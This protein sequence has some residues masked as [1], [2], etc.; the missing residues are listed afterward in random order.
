MSKACHEAGL[1][2]LTCGTYGNVLRF[3]PPLV[4]PEDDAAP[5]LAILAEAFAKRRRL[6]PLPRV[7]QPGSADHAR[8]DPAWLVAVA[9]RQ[10]HE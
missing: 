4:M 1:L 6:K 3:L 2:T 9:V 5:G 7:R 10:Q 8:R